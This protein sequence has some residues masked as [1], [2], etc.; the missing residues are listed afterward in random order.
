MA[1]MLNRF[2]SF[3]FVLFCFVLGVWSVACDFIRLLAV[4]CQLF[5]VSLIGSFI[6][7]E[8]IG[9]TRLQGSV[10]VWPLAAGYETARTRQVGAGAQFAGRGSG[11]GKGRS[12][13]SAYQS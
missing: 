10:C 12:R 6:G 2:F 13:H 9:C 11:R 5:L 3:R 8:C 4:N 7:H 1:K